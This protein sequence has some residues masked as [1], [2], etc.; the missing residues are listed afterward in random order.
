[1]ELALGISVGASVQV[2]LLVAPLLVLISYFLGRPM[3]LIFG[4]PWN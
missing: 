1:M 3:D 4:N 2:A